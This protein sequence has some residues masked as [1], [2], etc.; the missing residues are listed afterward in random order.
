LN[1][2]IEET[3]LSPE[4]ESARRLLD[5]KLKYKKLKQKLNQ[6]TE[7]IQDQGL[8]KD[9]RDITSPNKSRLMKLSLEL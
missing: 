6:L 9:Q 8:L 7:Q 3:A 4:K 5:N 1:Q 2:L